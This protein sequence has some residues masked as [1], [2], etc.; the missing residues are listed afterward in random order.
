MSKIYAGIGARITPR[1]ITDKMFKIACELAD[2]GWTLRSGGAA[3]ADSAFENGSS[4]AEIFRAN[5][6]TDAAMEFASRY[7]PAWA[8]CSPYARKLHGRNAMIILG[9]NLDNPVR[10]VLC[11]TESGRDEGGTGLAMRIAW[12]H[13][14]PVFNLKNREDHARVVKLI[15][16]NK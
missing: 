6:C 10:F 7:H 8:K 13:N 16:P 4:E 11:W 1:E 15:Q 3:G 2:L 5:D 9:E 12:S 14:I